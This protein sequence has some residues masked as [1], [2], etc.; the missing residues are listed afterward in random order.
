LKERLPK[1]PYDERVAV[2]KSLLGL[3]VTRTNF[4][5][6]WSESRI[7]RAEGYYSPEGYYAKM[8]ESNYELWKLA[9]RKVFSELR[10]AGL[11]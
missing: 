1:L 11:L 4:T 3:R 9:A 5:N 8:R 6:K 10:E 7:N 2:V